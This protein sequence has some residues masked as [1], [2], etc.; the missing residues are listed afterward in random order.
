MLQYLLLKLSGLAQVAL[1]RLSLDLL[2][3][4]DRYI[5]GV[6]RG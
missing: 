5:A 4:L 3:V 1:E 6:L 2:N